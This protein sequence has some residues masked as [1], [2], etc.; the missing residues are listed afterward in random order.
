MVLVHSQKQNEAPAAQGQDGER[1]RAP[2]S[3]QRGGPAA[4]PRNNSSMSTAV[5]R[6]VKA[7]FALHEPCSKIFLV[8]A[9]AARNWPHCMLR[10]HVTRWLGTRSL[11]FR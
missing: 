10:M 1:S 11:N 3:C 7:D 8:R 6:C 4:C 2:A 9:A 5:R